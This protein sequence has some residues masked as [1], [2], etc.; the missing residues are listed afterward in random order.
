MA[1]H[2]GVGPN[3]QA[4]ATARYRYEFEI[5]PTDGG[6]HATVVELAG[7][8]RRILEL[9]PATGYMSRAFR[10][11]GC[12]VVAIELDPDMARHA[13]ESC[14]R[15]IVGDLDTLDLEV[16]LG[17]DRFDVIVAADVLEHLKDPLSAL[18]RVGRFLRPD[19]FVVA[20]LPNVAHGSVRLALLEGRFDY[21]DLGLLDSTHLQFFTFQRVGEL[22]DEA[23]LCIVDLRRQDLDIE[24]SEVQYDRESVSHQVRGA[25]DADPNAHTYQ[26]VVKA[27]PMSQ[28][29][30]RELQ[31]ILREHADARTLAE[32]RADHLALLLAERETAIAQLINARAG[33]SED[34]RG[35]EL[36]RVLADLTRR[37]GRLRAAAIQAHDALLERDEEL[38]RRGEDLDA[39]GRELA[40]FRQRHAEQLRES[41]AVLAARE[42]E[43]RRVRL[44]LRRIL[45]SPPARLYELVRHRPGVR[46]IVALRTAAYDAE[47]RASRRL[48]D[49]DQ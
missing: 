31:R 1:P 36:R 6:T 9:G 47:L 5:D 25:L 43:L 18:R 7:C 46:R 35:V 49:A 45:E 30:F 19:G 20:S 26:F 40:A 24:A 33:Q 29:G 32:H 14:E 48:G 13:A 15:V 17:D 11:R 8:D 27:V 44:R 3:G 10:D 4:P 38:R 34:E 2:A 42:E 28:T 12:Q 22:F 21:R 41:A 16:E 39:I 37:E 23:E